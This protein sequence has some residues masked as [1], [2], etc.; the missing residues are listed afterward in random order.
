M[1]F[2]SNMIMF[3][4]TAM[5]DTTENMRS[6]II[7]HPPHLPDLAVSNSVKFGPL[8]KSCKNSTI[9]CMKR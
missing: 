3:T 9:Q 7:A 2:T 4:F 6:E 1:G 5:V 8:K